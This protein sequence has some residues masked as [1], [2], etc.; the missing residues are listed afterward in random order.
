MA[1]PP[2][3]GKQKKNKMSGLNKKKLLKFTKGFYG[4]A[5]NCHTI[6]RERAYKAL[7]YSFVG[8]KLKKREF[9]QTW[10]QQI[11]AGARQYGLSYSQFINGCVISEVRLDRKILAELAIYEP[12]SFRSVTKFV[13][14][15]LAQEKQKK[16]SKLKE[17]QSLQ[18]VPLSEVE[19]E[20]LLAQKLKEMQIL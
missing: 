4:R 16:A 19:E 7:T 6:A 12:Y 9:R 20:W 11:N 2:G 10:I 15:Q 5:K 18:Q 8:R 1:W 3:W 13:G 17:K 14:E